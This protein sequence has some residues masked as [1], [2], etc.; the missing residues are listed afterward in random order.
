MFRTTLALLVI[1]STPAALAA[2][3]D[4]LQPPIDLL[5]VDITV[6]LADITPAA[7]WSDVH[8]AAPGEAVSIGAVI[9]NAGQRAA[10]DVRVRLCVSS[11]SCKLR[12]VRALP[13]GMRR[14]VSVRFP[15][16]VAD[17]D[18]NPHYVTVTV[19][20]AD[21]IVEGDE[22]NNQRT[23]T[24]PYFVAELELV[25][26]TLPAEHD[27]IIQIVDGVVASYE[28]IDYGIDGAPSVN[29]ARPDPLKFQPHPET[30]Y[31]ETFDSVA[32][33]QPRIDPRV[34]EAEQA[35]ETGQRLR[36]LV[37]YRHNVPMPA[38]PALPDTSDRFAEANVPVLA[39]RLS[40]FE[41]V[42]R[43]R[44]EDANGLIGTITQTGGRVVE[45]FTLS[46]TLLVEAPK[47]ALPVI[48][49]HPQ[50]EH[51]EAEQ[52]GAAPPD[53]VAD[54]RSWIRT[55][56]YFN[57][58]AL[59][60]GFIALLDTGVRSTH[61]LLTGPDR[62]WFE[63]DCFNGDGNCNDIGVAAYDPDDD[64]W[65]HGTSTAAILTGNS[66]LGFG[67]RGVTE[68]WID[69]WKVYNCAGLN[70]T[71]TLRGYDQA[72]MWGDQIVV[73]EIQSR[74]G[75]TGSIAEAADDAFDAGTMTIA[76]N[77]NYGAEG[78][79]SV[80]SPANAHK[81]IGVG[82][83]D[84]DTGSDISSQSDGPTSD[85]RYKPDIQAPTN[86]DTASNVSDTAIRNFS[87]S[88]GATPYAAGA[89]SL[90]ADWYN[91]TALTSANAGKVYAGLINGGPL[92]WG[93]WNNSEGVGKFELPL[94]G[95]IYIGSRNL[96][97]EDNDRVTIDVPFGA[98]SISAAI[99]WPE[100]SADTHRDIDLY[101]ELPG[102]ATSDSS[103]SG[104]SVFEHVEV[105]G[106]IAAGERDV[107][108]YGYF[109]PSSATQ[110]V[111]YVIHVK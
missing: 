73:A 102:G 107:R 10:R 71:A 19:D 94:N 27:E 96:T 25:A 3:P 32:A 9:A 64:C 81:A 16:G 99:W 44:L 52:D 106:L 108:I 43:A 70:T 59:G 69:S 41:A 109:V 5:P 4:P 82:N 55:D 2:G 66:N 58:G 56:P 39:Q 21:T 26:P 42:R 98:T 77:G 13:A 45:D 75:D 105:N 38:L 110:T 6:P 50:V 48:G 14:Q 15:A 46:G 79:G 92:D 80:A 60:D 30:G 31:T 24:K 11:G 35:A 88:S 49:S 67:S 17:V 85:G 12:T 29:E 78:A 37:K 22:G 86:T 84:V 89:A 76:A 101:L 90:F 83:Y 74:Q 33:P 20:P 18:R 57:S 72:V 34:V 63:E 23:T 93:N 36:Y 51:V 1:A 8:V 65:N 95:T 40:R 100:N 68:S 61:T 7:V 111:Y 97:D 87:G 91:K 62:I 103:I 54:G 53:S 104:V 28:R 47:G